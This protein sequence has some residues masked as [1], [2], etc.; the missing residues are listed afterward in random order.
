MVVY[1]F[2]SAAEQMSVPVSVTWLA[3]RIEVGCSPAVN[4]HL[5]R[6]GDGT[7]EWEFG[8]F[9]GRRL[10]LA[11]DTELSFDMTAGCRNHWLESNYNIQLDSYRR[12]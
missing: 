5:T 8:V 11:P 4:R 7:G 10:I 6:N 2:A 12:Q 9:V 1:L 3:C